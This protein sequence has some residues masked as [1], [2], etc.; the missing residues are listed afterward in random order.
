MQGY[1][2]RP[3]REQVETIRESSVLI[4]SESPLRQIQSVDVELKRCRREVRIQLELNTCTIAPSEIAWLEGRQFVQRVIYSVN[5]D[6][7]ELIS[8]VSAH[9]VE[10][11]VHPLVRLRITQE[12]VISRFRRDVHPVRWQRMCG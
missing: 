5:L 4:A 8:R 6:G 3:I 9:H 1:E 12:V 11:Q 7:H 10:S 2:L